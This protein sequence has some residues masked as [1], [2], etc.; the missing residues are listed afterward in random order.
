MIGSSEGNDEH[1]KWPRV[2][3]KINI[4]EVGGKNLWLRR[5]SENIKDIGECPL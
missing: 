5:K 1:C 4:S 2:G 3:K